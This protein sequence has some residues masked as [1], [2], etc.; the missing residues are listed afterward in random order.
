MKEES[1]YK[2]VMKRELVFKIILWIV[3]ILLVLISI[4]VVFMKYINAKYIILLSFFIFFITFMIVE[5][6]PRSC[7]VCKI[8][9]VKYDNGTN[10]CFKCE[11]C[12]FE[13]RTYISSDSL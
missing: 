10:V 12:D 8:R 3:S 11:K 2:K 9:M 5:F 6:W 4:L 1:K 13:I 7:P